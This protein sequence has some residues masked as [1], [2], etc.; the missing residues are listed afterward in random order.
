MTA[1]LYFK[2]PHALIEGRLPFPTVTRV[3][4]LQLFPTEQ[5]DLD[6]VARV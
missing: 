1:Q 5:A 3:Y 6:A 2:K 4:A